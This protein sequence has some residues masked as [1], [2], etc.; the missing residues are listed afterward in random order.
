MEGGQGFVG[1]WVVSPSHQLL[2]SRGVGG[3][4]HIN[5]QHFQQML[6]DQQDVSMQKNANWPMSISLYK[7]Q[8]QVDQGPPNKIRHTEIYRGES[9][10]KP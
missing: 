9:G 3:S 5:F 10:E 6:L 8:V 1:C 2:A 7:S 4:Y